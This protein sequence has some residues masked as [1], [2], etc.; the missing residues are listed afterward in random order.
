MTTTVRHL[1]S[2][3]AVAVAAAIAVAPAAN[4]APNSANCQQTGG[5]TSCQKDGHF[6]MHVKPQVRAPSGSL[7]GSAWLPGYGRGQL[8]PL[9]ALD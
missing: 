6:S 9:L 7:F 5:S 8:P 4:A 3:V 2:A 1:I